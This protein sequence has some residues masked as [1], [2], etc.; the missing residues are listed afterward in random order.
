LSLPKPGETCANGRASSK[1][2]QAPKRSVSSTGL[3]KSRVLSFLQCPKRLWLERNRPDEAVIDGSSQFVF[4]QGHDVGRVA[5]TLYPG[6]HLIAHD[7]DLSEAL[8]ETHKRVAGCPRVPLFEATFQHRGTLVR[9]DVLEPHGRAGWHLRE[10]KSS[11]QV[12]DYHLDD[13][14]IQRWVATGAGIR[15]N[16]ASLMRVNTGW[17]YEGN[18]DY[19]GLLVDEDVTAQAA[20]IEPQVA[21]WV[22]GAQRV[23]RGDVPDVPMGDQC[24]DPF[25]CPFQMYCSRGLEQVEFPVL[26]LPGPGGKAL[27]RR[28]LDEG[29]V[30]LRDV[31]ADRIDDPLYSLIHRVTKS[32]RR[33]LDASVGNQLKAL[34]E[35]VLGLRNDRFLDL[36]G[37]DPRRRCA[38][39]LVR[40][41]RGTKVV[42]A[43]NA[44][45]ERGCLLRLAAMFPD[46]AD[47]LGRVASML[48]DLLPLVR[49]HYYHRSMLGSYSLKAVLPTMLGHDP[50]A[51]LGG[52]Q[53][54][55]LAQ[56]LYYETLHS[57]ATGARHRQVGQQLCEYCRLD[58]W[59]L[60]AVAAFLQRKPIPPKPMR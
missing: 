10:V 51:A 8:A 54:G 27:A 45:F 46:L 30:D 23:L 3:S 42:L 14:A 57:E 21:R 16:R 36:S 26:L 50:Y 29:F 38:Q 59:S 39:A 41:L 18:G 4:D 17:T 34:P 2:R 31:P 58:T 22:A 49:R 47:D 32:G 35:S 19:R 60:I 15:L 48:F 33:H 11:S 25:D 28:L 9:V 13:V 56:S 12:K 7:D 43:Y 53:S 24:T 55:S 6:G 20:E 1:G 5:R 37:A 44:S 40:A 52:V